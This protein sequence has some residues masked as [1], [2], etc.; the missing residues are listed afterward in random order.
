MKIKCLLRKGSVY[1]QCDSA[2]TAALFKE[3]LSG[4]NLP[5]YKPVTMGEFR[6][7]LARIKKDSKN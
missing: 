5:N 2:Q 3:A 4:S 7:G 1:Y 6:N